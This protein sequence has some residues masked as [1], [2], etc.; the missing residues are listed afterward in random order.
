M[1]TPQPPSVSFLSAA[2][3]ASYAIG[4]IGR[5]YPPAGRDWAEDEREMKAFFREVFL[6]GCMVI[7]VVS[8]IAAATIALAIATNKL[9]D[10]SRDWM[11]V[12]FFAA[13]GFAAWIA[14]SAAKRDL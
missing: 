10:Y 1:F 9:T 13:I 7:A 8:E 12:A 6:I 3:C 2:G 11:A 14:G 5:G 4:T